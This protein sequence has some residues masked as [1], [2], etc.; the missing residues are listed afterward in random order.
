MPT[1]VQIWGQHGY[2]REEAIA[3][4]RAALSQP[5]MLRDDDLTGWAQTQL[6]VQ[7]I[8]DLLPTRA[9]CTRVVYDAI[10]RNEGWADNAARPWKREPWWSE[11]PGFTS[12]TEVR[13]LAANALDWYTHEFDADQA[14]T[15]Y[16]V[17][18]KA[19][20]ARPLRRAGYTVAE[21]QA[22][23]TAARAARPRGRTDRDLI[24][25]RLLREWTDL[26]LLAQQ[27]VS[28]LRAGLTSNEAAWLTTPEEWQAVEVLAALCGAENS[29]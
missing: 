21:V 23:V 18:D 4:Y 26:G 13:N 20:E 27:I 28:A 1:R 14:V 22:M 12:P 7:V 11:D 15:W 3:I 9:V 24:Y 29:R 5:G 10:W 17:T 6:P 2:T 8:I 16:A 19:Y 25:H